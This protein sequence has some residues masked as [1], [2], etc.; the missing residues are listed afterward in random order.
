MHVYDVSLSSPLR[1]KKITSEGLR[2]F[3]A[4]GREVA[5]PYRAREGPFAFPYRGGPFRVPFGEVAFPY[6]GVRLRT[7][8]EYCKRLRM[9]GLRWSLNAVVQ[10]NGLDSRGSETHYYHFAY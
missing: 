10:K 1:N 9:S 4:L 6:R 5:F 3:R 2:L 7:D 8:L